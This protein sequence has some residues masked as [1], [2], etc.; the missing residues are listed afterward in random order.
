M[1]LYTPMSP[2]LVFPVSRLDFGLEK[3]GDYGK[4]GEYK[5]VRVFRGCWVPFFYNFWGEI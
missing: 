5:S 3:P 1:L 2:T 4:D